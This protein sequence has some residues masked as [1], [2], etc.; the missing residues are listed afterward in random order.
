MRGMEL[1]GDLLEI[2]TVKTKII[3]SRTKKTFRKSEAAI[4]KLL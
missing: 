1:N 2:N 4:Y 3:E